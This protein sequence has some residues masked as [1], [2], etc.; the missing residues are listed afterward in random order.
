MKILVVGAGLSGLVA[1]HRLQAAGHEVTILEARPRVGGRVLTLRE[2]FAEGQHADVGAMILYEG[3]N[4]ILDLC[5]EFGIKLTPV[6]T[7]GAELPRVRYGGRLLG[8]EEIG[9]CFGELGK[10]QSAHPAE[11]FETA[12]AWVRRCRLSARAIALL[13]AFIEIQPS[14]PLRFVDARGLHLGPERYVQ[15]ADGND[16]LPR[17]LAQGLD[18]RFE[19]VVRLIDWSSSS[20]VVETEKGQFEGDLL[21]LAV[22]GPL[23]TDIG[24][25]PPLPAE[26]V[27]ALVSLRYGTGAAVAAQ[28]RERKGVSDAVRTAFFSD[29][30]PRWMLDLSVDQPG[31]AAIVT[32]ILSA[33][34]EP[35]GLAQNDVLGEIDSAL[36]EITRSPVTRLGGAMVSWTD[37]PFARCIARAPI[38]DQRETVL[39]EIKRP[40]SKR[41]FFAG[42]HTDER[43]GPG[44]MDGAIRSG[45]RVVNEVTD[46]RPGQSSMDDA[47]RPGPWTLDKIARAARVRWSFSHPSWSQP[48]TSRR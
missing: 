19:H 39:H 37:D 26:K 40:L 21:V 28:Y 6:K 48:P 23:T 14:I 5:R 33:D 3:Q 44:G 20:V 46:A 35:R 27:R 36:T 22:P 25:N 43:P 11:P 34:S 8:P 13:D 24:W 41:V 30:I 18:V 45:L 31:N 47:V 9:A 29:S 4:T 15:M 2:P 32:T 17:R 16:Q 38:G 1:A 10:A 42:E 7:V 12:A